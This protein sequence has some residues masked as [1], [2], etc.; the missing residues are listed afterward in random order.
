MPPENQPEPL[1]KETPP[2]TPPIPSPEASP[3]KQIRTFQG[4]VANA[5][6]NQNESIFSI[7]QA[8]RLKM[9]R[10]DTV[11]GAAEPE[12]RGSEMLYFALGG[13]VLI[14]L[15]AFG[16][17]FG[18]REFEQRTAPPTIAVPESRFIAVQSEDKLNFAS[19]SREAL[20]AFINEKSQGVS[21]NELRHFALRKGSNDATPLATAA[22]FLARLETNAP[23][24]LV[25]SF[26]PIFML[27]TLGNSRFIIFRLSSFENAFPGMLTWEATMPRDIGALF[28]N[29]ESLKSIGPESV[30]KDVIS[31]N[32]DVRVLE[33][34]GAPALLYSFFD[35]Q[36][37]IITDSLETLSTLVDRLTQELLSR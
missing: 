34:G 8:E 20:I 1:S 17:W 37:L 16:A 9:S 25:R 15:G 23:G 31:R 32:K 13:A 7:Q 18:Y 36:M 24:N 21:A 12:G 10:G 5:L 33:V 14:V 22:E 29:A 6:G 3:L 26:E 27:G 19:T 35:N 4:D 30:F 28:A 2:Q 11:P